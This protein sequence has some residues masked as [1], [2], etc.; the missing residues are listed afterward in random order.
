LADKGDRYSLAI[1][2]AILGWVIPGGGYAVIKDYKRAAIVFVVLTLMF[3]TGLYVGSLAVIDTINAH[4]WYYAQI[5]FSPVVELI[6]RSNASSGE[7]VYGRPS[8]IGQ[9]YTSLAGMLNLVCAVKAAAIAAHG[10]LVYKKDKD[11]EMKKK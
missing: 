1:T 10:D 5:L 11:K 9:L 4:A 6:A 3:G 7:H 8:E 2:A